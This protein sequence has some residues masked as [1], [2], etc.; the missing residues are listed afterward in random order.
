[1][2]WRGQARYPSLATQRKNH[3][4]PPHPTDTVTPNA[5]RALLN[6]VPAMLRNLSLPNRFALIGGVVLLIAAGVLAY[7]N[8]AVSIAQLKNMAEEN[9]VALTFALS[10]VLREDV[11][12]LMKIAPDLSVEALKDHPA[13]HHID[14]AVAEASLGTRI[15]KVKIYSPSGLTIYSS[16]PTQIGEDK[17]A[18]EGFLSA[19]G[20]IVVSTLTYRDQFDSFEKTIFER[21]LISSYIPIFV[22]ETSPSPSGVFEIYSDV[23]AL[24]NTISN[25]VWLILGATIGI[26]LIVYGVVLFTVIGGSRLVSQKHQENL[27]LELE[28]AERRRS[29]EIARV[30]LDNEREMGEI[31][32]NFIASV[33]HEFRTP[34]TTIY[35]AADIM[36]R[37]VERLDQHEV[38]ENLQDIKKQVSAITFVL[39]RI[40]I[41]SQIGANKL[42]CNPAA[43]DLGPFCR[44]LV[45]Q[46]RHSTSAQQ[47]I[48]LVIDGD[49]DPVV[50]DERLVRHILNN[51]I[52]N[53]I[54]YSSQGSTID[55]AVS[56]R[57]NEIELSVRD[58]GIGIEAAEM[59]RIFEQYF[60]G[61]NAAGLAGTGLGLSIVKSAAE[62][63]G[64]RV[65]VN[66]AAG[67]G[68]EFI[69]RIPLAGPAA[70]RS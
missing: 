6:R 50:L 37:Y 30:A 27:D 14:D 7:V 22:R 47:T 42:E 55:I 39:D 32:S 54:K 63:H 52:S 67:E 69:V 4:K 29:E 21:D 35:A 26:L 36:D 70:G 25:R 45:Q 43:M 56:R 60:R 17:S 57:A 31:R 49:S 33:S 38:K 40:L 18:N 61:E 8:Q 65:E 19:I 5:A 41:G 59:D 3:A 53:A 68:A 13:L 34:L 51:L 10:N 15:V 16:D 2:A 24:K 28:L 9:N 44:D 58:R 20:N 11:A 62:V 12:M 48:N 66:S 46:M 23:T 64:G 1:M